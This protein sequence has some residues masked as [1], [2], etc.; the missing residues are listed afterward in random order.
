MLRVR[1]ASSP[2]I[3]CIYSRFVLVFTSHIL[4]VYAFVH[5]DVLPT[6]ARLGEMTA[7]WEEKD[8]FEGTSLLEGIL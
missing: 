3:F 1:F 7:H 6:M 2:C 5:L 8:S 4:H